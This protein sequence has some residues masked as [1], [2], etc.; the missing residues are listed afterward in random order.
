MKQETVSLSQETGGRLRAA[1]A[2]W[3]QYKTMYLFMLPFIVLF[4]VFVIAPVVTAVYLSFTYFNMLEPPRWIGL[5]NYRLLFLED[6]I[7]FTAIKN[8]LLFS[9]ITGPLSYGIS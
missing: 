3:R 1:R 4:L 7:F 5:S 9:L 2:A 6:D 8:T